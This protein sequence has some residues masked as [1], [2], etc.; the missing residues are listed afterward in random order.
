MLKMANRSALY[1]RESGEHGSLDELGA[2]GTIT[3]GFR[4]F[5]VMLAIG[6]EG[7]G[8]SGS[9]TGV[10]I[11]DIARLRGESGQPPEV[12]RFLRAVD[13]S[14]CVE[15]ILCASAI[16]NSSDPVIRQL[17]CA[18]TA[19]KSLNDRHTEIYADAVRLAIVARLICL[20]SEARQSTPCPFGIV[21]SSTKRQA[22]V[23]Q[24]WRLKRVLE[25]IDKHLAEKILLSDLA[26]VS[27][28]SRMHFAAQFRAAMNLR[29][30]EYLLR[31]RIKRAEELLCESAM[32][33]VEISLAVGFQTQAHFTTAFKRFVGDT[34]H[35]WRSRLEVCV[36]AHKTN[37]HAGN[38]FSPIKTRAVTNDIH[39][40]L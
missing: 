4:H 3:L 1:P 29:P 37:R 12:E 27:G 14:D 20:Q 10:A 9:A 15:D 21:D 2:E 26:A 6:A 8:Q 35:R 28:L 7:S 13:R 36:D 16:E 40:D 23:L 24:K 33:L 39:L 38:L 19:T 17:S 22:R 11:P 5:E 34:P 32:T 31:R 30:H 18:L 25:Y